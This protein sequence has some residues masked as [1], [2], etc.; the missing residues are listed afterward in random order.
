MSSPSL[1]KKCI[2]V[3]VLENGRTNLYRLEEDSSVQNLIEMISSR[4]RI[5]KNRFFLIHAGKVLDASK[6][7][8]FYGISEA[9]SLTLSIK[10]HSFLSRRQLNQLN[11]EDISCSSTN[12]ELKKPS[13]KSNL[14]KRKLVP[15]DISISSSNL[16]LKKPSP[17]KRQLTQCKW[18][19]G[20]MIS[21]EFNCPSMVQIEYHPKR[22]KYYYVMLP[23]ETACE[24]YYDDLVKQL[25]EYGYTWEDIKQL[26]HDDDDLVINSIV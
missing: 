18:E 22:G 26:E 8:N 12:L 6:S 23:N 21:Q 9:S 5:P 19:T 25:S 1:C 14:L 3:F 13:P 11:E 10:H 15:E 17:I 4:S 7:L 24:G 16:D 2:Q 20:Y